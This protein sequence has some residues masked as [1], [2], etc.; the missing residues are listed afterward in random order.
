MRKSYRVKKEAEFQNV[1]EKHNSVANRTFVIYQMEKPDQ[2]H[3]RVGISV[4][5]KIGN[6]VHR[7]WVKRRV[8]QSLTELKPYLRQDV[9]FLVIARPRADQLS[10]EEVKKNMVHVLKLANLLDSDY[11]EGED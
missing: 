8:R 1:F 6:A 9:D 5:K 11:V 2:P 7:N 10:M 4:G 3:F